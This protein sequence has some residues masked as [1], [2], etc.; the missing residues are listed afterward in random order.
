MGFDWLLRIHDLI[1][2]EVVG[3]WG[4]GWDGVGPI[5][6]SSDRRRTVVGRRSQTRLEIPLRKWLGML[7]SRDG[8]SSS[9][10]TKRVPIP[11]WSY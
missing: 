4:G 9:T 1:S 7:P 2:Q 5:K 11:S 6:T 10:V 3:T 8:A